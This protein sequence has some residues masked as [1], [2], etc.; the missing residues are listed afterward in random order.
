MNILADAHVH[1]YQEDQLASALQAAC[2]NL[3]NLFAPPALNNTNIYKV[4]FLTE[5]RGCN[6]YA[7][8]QSGTLQVEGFKRKGPEDSGL[9]F[10]EHAQL[11][12]IAIAPGRQIISH[13]KLEV[14]CYLQDLIIP[15]GLPFGEI[16]DHI[17]A[18]SGVA[19]INWA[20]GKWMFQRG[21]IISELIEKNPPGRFIFCDTSLRPRSWPRS[22]LLRQA[23]SK[24][25]GVVCGTDPFPFPGEETRIGTYATLFENIPA[26]KINASL[27][28]QLLLQPTGLVKFLGRRLAF[29]QVIYRVIRIKFH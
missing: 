12:E 16:L 6:V 20:P 28:K 10:F 23:Q 15:D 14:L 26:D 19:A 13:E 7:K 5:R 25:F 8:L 27:L 21:K 3:D 29:P 1:L 9:L 17:N 2:I 4:L 18:A 22:K 24:G 11:G